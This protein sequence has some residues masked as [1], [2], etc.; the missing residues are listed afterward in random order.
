[1]GFFDGGKSVASVFF[2]ERLVLAL[3]PLSVASA[4]QCL[5]QPRLFI[6][7]IKRD[8]KALLILDSLTS[9]L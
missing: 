1:M 3:T 5:C 4:V 9:L 2:T 6:L 8:Q 7:I